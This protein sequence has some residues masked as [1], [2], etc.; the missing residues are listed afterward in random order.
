MTVDARSMNACATTPVPEKPSIN[1]S[2]FF[3]L[4]H[5]VFMMK[6][7][8]RYFEPIYFLLCISTAS[9]QAV[10]KCVLCAS[11]LIHD[12]GCLCMALF[13]LLYINKT[14]IAIMQYR[15]LNPA[16]IVISLSYNNINIT[17]GPFPHWM[18]SLIAFSHGSSFNSQ[19][20]RLHN[21]LSC[22]QLQVL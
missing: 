9:I 10:F 19:I 13:F 5:M 4:P 11:E 8:R 17:T 6:G 3:T 20:L 21:S 2:I 15:C 1:V 7:S 16:I 14:F 12:S 18:F 22:K